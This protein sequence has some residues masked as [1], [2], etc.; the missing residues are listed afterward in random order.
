M[1]PSSPTGG[2]EPAGQVADPLLERD[3]AQRLPQQRVVR[4]GG[5]ERGGCPR[6]SRTT[7][8]GRWGS[9]ATSA[10]HAGPPTGRPAA[11]TEPPDRGSSPASAASSVD[12]P[13]PDG[14]VST[15]TP[16][17][18]DDRVE[19]RRRAGRSGRRT[20]RVTSASTSGVPAAAVA[21]T[22]DSGVVRRE[23]VDGL[24][25][26]HALGGGVELRA[27]PAQRPV[28]LRRE[29]QH[30]QR[31]CA[32]RGRPAASR[33]PDGDRDQRDATAW[34][35]ARAPPRRRRPAAACRSDAPAVAVGDL[36][37]PPR[38]APGPGGRRPASAARA[39]RRGSAPR[40][41]TSPATAVWARS[42]V[43]R[44]TRAPNTGTSGSVSSTMSALSRSWVAIATTVSSGSTPASTSG[45][46]VAGEVRL[47]G[48]DATGGEHRELTGG[49]RRTAGGAPARIAADHAAPQVGADQRGGRRGEHVGEPAGHGPGAQHGQH[50]ETP[51][52]DV[53]VVEDRDDQAGDREGLGDHQQTA[54]DPGDEDPGQ[55]PPAGASCARI[56]GSVGLI[57][58]PR[59]VPGR[60]CGARRSAGGTP[61]RSSPGRSARAG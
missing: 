32:G 25:R 20:S 44:P 23:R 3:P 17:A 12:L 8:T 47:G 49:R 52:A 10:R 51:E 5:G 11:V 45:R 1:A 35:P 57:G 28:G 43:A 42:R 18:G 31:R 36:A 22:P 41:T 37:D 58:R 4:V 15:V 60:G 6:R 55:G 24:E 29:Q 34:R 38:T 59:P 61:S 46:H 21:S 48:A 9:Q 19:V 27:D 53:A 26:R 7:N 13:Q 56:R 14:P 40:A 16:R 33:T 2:V 30:D 54:G 50:D 39:P